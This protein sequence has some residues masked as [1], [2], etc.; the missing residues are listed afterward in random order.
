MDKQQTYYVYIGTYASREDPGIYVYTLNSDTGELAFVESISG[1]DNPSYLAIDSRKQHLYAVSETETF[2]GQ[3]GGSV[4][5]YSIQPQTGKLTWLNQQPTLGEAPCF[6]SVDHRG[7]SLLVVNYFGG[8]LSIFPLQEDGMIGTLTA[9][10]QHV[11][12][13]VRADRQEA[14]H[15][16]SIPIDPT[17]SYAFVPDLGLD[18]IFVYQLDY[19]AHMLSLRGEIEVEAGSGPR[20]L[21][22]HP[23][24]KYAYVLNELAS[25]I[26]A[27]ATDIEQATL[28]PIQTISLLPADFVGENTSAE[29]RISPDGRFLYGSNRGDDSIAVFSIQQDTGQLTYVEHVSTLGKTPRN[30]NL[31]PDGRFLFAANQDSDSIITYTVDQA[32][33]RLT[34][35]GQTLQ[36]PRPVCI[37]FVAA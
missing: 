27:F 15:P 17:G 30:F 20:H 29:V 28:H 7:G 31:A 35:T 26:T 36:I 37:L 34:P 21:L 22:F 13:G 10:I 2:Q 8:N 32:T 9:H 5:A 6:V 18:R 23:S 25:T 1:I 11:G 16:H 4:A 14:P 24:L 19:D 33:G 12:K 3:E